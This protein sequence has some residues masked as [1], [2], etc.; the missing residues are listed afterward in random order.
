M[1]L[2]SHI[3]ALVAAFDLEEV[4]LLRDAIRTTE[5]A[6]RPGTRHLEPAAVYE[7]RRHIHPEPIIEPRRHIR[8]DPLIQPRRTPPTDKGTLNP[9]PCATSEPPPTI[10]AENPIQPPWK[11]LPWRQPPPAAPLK[12]TILR[13][14]IHI[15]K[16][17]LLDLFI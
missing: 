2:A 14:D 9:C 10:P 17:S 4:R 6:N 8:P 1:S 12:L 11:S 16:G 7:P 15:S 5:A 13:P 3:D